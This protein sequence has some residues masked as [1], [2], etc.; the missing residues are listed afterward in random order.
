MQFGFRLHRV[1]FRDSTSMI[2]EYFN[3]C[4]L[5][6]VQCMCY[7]CILS[8]SV[9]MCYFCACSVC[10]ICARS[11]CAICACS[12]CAICACSVCAICAC[13]VAMCYLCMQC[14]E[15]EKQNKIIQSQS[16]GLPAELD[17]QFIR[18]STFRTGK[19]QL[20]SSTESEIMQSRCITFFLS[21]FYHF[22]WLT[23]V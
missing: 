8:C 23:R 18:Y 7:L 15:N 17:S 16:V 11:V 5:C 9:A 21:G 14:I 4:Y 12:V 20:V 1:V 22:L 6:I 13:S 10:A 19:E 2:N 3:L